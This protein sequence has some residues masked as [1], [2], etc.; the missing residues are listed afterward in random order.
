MRRAYC[1]NV[2]SVRVL[3]LLAAMSA[4]ASADPVTDA[5]LG[6]PPAH[7]LVGDSWLELGLLRAR[8]AMPDGHQ[9]Q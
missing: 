2:T 6:R 4:T 7:S 1:E 8:I 9:V 5:F 3:F